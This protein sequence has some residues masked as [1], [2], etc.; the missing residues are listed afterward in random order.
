MLKRIHHVAVVV[1]SADEALRFYRDS[2]G[3]AVT[4]DEVI[5]D[6]GV[7]GVLLQAGHGEI[8][9]IE[10]VREGTGVA[11]FLETRGEGLHHICFE[12]DDV[13]A[14]LTAAKAR[15]L[16]LIDETPRRGLAGMIGFVHPRSA[17]GVLV[18]F[19]TPPSGAH[20][21]ARGGMAL[22]LDHVGVAVTDMDAGITLW[23]QNFGL[24]MS[25]R[26]DVPVVQS[27]AVLP[28]GTAYVEL[29]APLGEDGPLQRWLARRGEG[30]YMFSL[31]VADLAA[32]SAELRRRGLPVSEPLD[33]GSMN[34]AFV[35]PRDTHGVL[36]EL[37][38]PVAQ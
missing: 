17:R 21:A 18:E 29:L 7:R 19:A 37:M 11:R 34:A 1:R 8:E 27:K 16:S 24:E 9:L 36:I 38:Q 13:A 22:N 31:E 28:I 2:L 12:T 25:R 3:L 23:R 26:S 20:A 14:E 32:A 5:A 4:D 33:L 35:H 10:P 6:Q 15:G 30:L